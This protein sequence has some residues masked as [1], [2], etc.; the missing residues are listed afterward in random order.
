[1][2]KMIWTKSLQFKKHWKIFDY[3]ITDINKN[4]IQSFAFNLDFLEGIS[5]LVIF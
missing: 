5:N 1:M 4:I 2:L 3:R